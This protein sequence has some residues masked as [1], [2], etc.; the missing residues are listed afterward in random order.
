MVSATR[1]KKCFHG[2]W[3]LGAAL[4]VLCPNLAQAAQAP[5]GEA[6]FHPSALATFVLQLALLVMAARL[7]GM[8]FR[9]WH[10]PSLLGE[11]AAGLLLGPHVL[12]ILLR[13]EMRFITDVTWDNNLSGIVMLAMMVLL[14][15]V[16]IETDVRALRRHSL[17][18][19][20]S[21]LGGTLAAMVAACVT[22]VALA[23]GLT[24]A[25]ISW[26]APQ[27]IFVAVA[28]AVTSPGIVARLLS[29]QQRMESPE[30]RVALSGVAADNLLAV[31]LLT[32]AAGIA[33]GV[34]SGQ[35]ATPLLAA[36]SA[37]VAIIAGVVALLI[38]ILLTR[39]LDPIFKEDHDAIGPAVLGLGL[40][41]LTGGFL[42]ETGLLPLM[43]AYAVGV[44]FSMTDIRHHVQDRLEFMHAAFVPACFAL[45]GTRVD[46]ALLIRPEVL[47]FA[48]ILSI[49][50]LLAK[51]IGAGL[52]T[53]LA[54]LNPMGGLRVGICM[55]PRGEMTLA[56]LAVALSAAAMPPE[57]LAAVVLVLF[58][59]GLLAPALTTAVF[60]KGGPGTQRGYPVSTE[61]RQTFAFP[62]PDAASLILS[63]LIELFE[64][65]GFSVALLHRRDFLYQ[66]TRGSV[67]VG[68]RRA[69]A[70]IIFTCAEQDREL[71][72][73]AMLEVAA[74]MERSLK[75][76]RKPLDAAALR[77]RLQTSND[78]NAGAAAP[79]GNSALRDYITVAAMRPRLRAN[80]KTGVIQELLDMLADNG[81]VRDTK[82]AERAVLE[83]E[84]GFSTGLQNGIA[85]PHGR[86][87]AVN[88]LVCAVGL[89]PE[90]V[91]FDT[92][93]GKPARI[94]MLV[95]APQHATAPQLQFLSLI[96]RTLTETTRSA[97]LACDTAEDMYAVLTDAPRLKDARRGGRAAPP[98]ACLAWQ[99]IALDLGAVSKEEAL[100]RLLALCTRSGAVIAPDEARK[101]IFDREREGSTG[102][103]SGVALPHARTAAVDRMVCAFGISRAGIDFGAMDGKP[104]HFFAMVLMPPNASTEY[105]RLIGALARALDTDGRAALLATRS[106]QDALAILTARCGTHP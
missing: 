17:A 27:T 82:Q 56:T 43:G 94:I 47:L 3:L 57:F 50:V 51:T 95:L 62:S 106:S 97:L 36:R 67:V 76:L 59:S 6:F 104:S 68:L 91:D 87:D 96:S 29:H 22:T 33:Q 78:A 49:A 20:L 4:L 81:L 77:L 79:V 90:G 10:L 88:R 25:S 42:L 2:A 84:Q 92:L 14:F 83:R 1:S 7:G 74:S 11:V 86:T 80:D 71:V 39:R 85:L 26:W 28:V 24:S 58:V 46:P 30:G 73:T 66:L 100:D 64:E 45:V 44:A 35:P 105:T 23:H 98:L 75:E 65:E 19:I 40:A 52:P 13:P 72:N 89:K 21:G 63:R 41:L 37:F 38:A 102:I 34:A 31:W 48:G 99:S 70:E 8:L 61:S 18:G 103:E 5:V 69:N 16:G 32:T 15:L 93:D 55:M 60:T 12:G 101:A 9:K 53:L 54:G